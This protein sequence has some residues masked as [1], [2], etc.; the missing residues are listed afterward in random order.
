MRVLIV[1]DEEPLK[2]LLQKRLSRRGLVVDAFES[3][4][5]AA[6]MLNQVSYDVALVDIRL[7]GMDGIELLRCIKEEG[8]TEVIILTGHGTIDSAI[9]AMKLGAYDYLTKPCKLS[10]LELVVQKAHEKKQLKQGYSDLKGELQRRNR[11]GEVIGRSHAMSEVTDLVERISQTPSTVL[12]QG[13]TGTG[14]ELIANE[15]HRRSLRR[16]D[17]FIVIHCAALP[18]TLQESELFGY[19]KGAFTGAAKQKRGLV[20]LADRGT[21]FI[22]EVGEIQPQLQVK[23]LRFLETGKFRRLGGESEHQIDARI[24]AAT[25]R[26]LMGEVEAGRFRED[27]YYRLKVASIQLPPLRERKEDIPLLVEHFLERTG[28]TKQITRPALDKLAECDWPG[29]VREL[30]NTL[31]VV[32]ALCRGRFIRPED[33]AIQGFAVSSKKWE[34]LADLEKEHIRQVLASCAG[35]KTKTAGILGISVRNLYRKIEKYR[36]S[37]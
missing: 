21:L 35:N 28:G 18:E 5:D 3:A 34:S 20:E 36:L 6:T 17:P 15:I 24:I 27:L 2:K 25:N 4:E 9:S 23:L 1:E 13:E 33:L 14:K 31:E 22:D 7:P 30:A 19:E 16:E 12:V 11:Y 32:A 37:S 26:D 8:E 10:E 29:N